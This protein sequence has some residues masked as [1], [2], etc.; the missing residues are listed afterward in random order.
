[1]TATPGWEGC[2]E[3]GPLQGSSWCFQKQ[4]CDDIGRRLTVLEESWAQGKLSAPVRK[5]MS[6]LV[7]GEGQGV[8]HK[9]P[10]G[11]GSADPELDLSWQSS[12]NATGTQQMKSTAPSWW[13]M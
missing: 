9:P 12:S 10:P 2:P 11:R 13:T 6:L 7:Q 8:A 1:M 3:A 5:R 4:V